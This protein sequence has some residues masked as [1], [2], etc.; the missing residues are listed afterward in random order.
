MTA[1]FEI[2]RIAADHRMVTDRIVERID[3]IGRAA[4]ARAAW[5]SRL[6]REGPC[7]P[8][9]VAQ[10]GTATTPAPQLDRPEAEPEPPQSWLS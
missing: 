2:E 9:V 8:P 3:A 1:R 6:P 5:L 10:P 4:A 7:A